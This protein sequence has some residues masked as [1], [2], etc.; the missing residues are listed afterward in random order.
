MNR[1]FSMVI[2]QIG[3][4][5]LAIIEALEKLQDRI[6]ALEARLAT[7]D[8]PAAEPPNIRVVSR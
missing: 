7:R 5:R 3:F 6:A 1:A 8:E 2:G 4:S